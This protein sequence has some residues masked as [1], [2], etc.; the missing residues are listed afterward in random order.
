MGILAQAPNWTVNPSDYQFTSTLTGVL[1][2]NDTLINSGNNQLGAFVNGQV[3]GVATPTQIG[4]TDQYFITL[5]SNVSSGEV[6]TFQAYLALEDSIH[7]VIDT[8]VY[9]SSS[10]YGDPATP[11]ELY[12]NQNNNPRFT[13]VP[14]LGAIATDPFDVI[15]L[16]D[17]TLNP[18]NVA[19]DYQV[20]SSTGSL[21]VSLNQDSLNVM[22]MGDISRDSVLVSIVDSLTPSIR[23]DSTYIVYEVYP[24]NA[25]ISFDSIE[26]ILWG[27]N[28]SFCVDLNNYLV[29]D[30][31]DSIIWTI[32]SSPLDS[33]GDTIVSWSVNAP[34]YQYS[35]NVIAESFVNGISTVGGGFQLAA[36]EGAN[37]IGVTSPTLVN[38]KWLYFMTIY[39]NTTTATID[40]KLWNS[41]DSIVLEERTTELQFDVDGVIGGIDSPLDLS[42]GAYNYQYT[43]GLLCFDLFD[44]IPGLI[45]SILVI[46]TEVNTDELFTDSLE[47]TVS[48][49][50]ENQP[51]LNTIPEQH[52]FKGQSF[53]SF[54]LDDYLI[55]LDGDNVIYEVFNNDSIIANIDGNNV[56]TLTPNSAT[57]IGEEELLFKVT[58]QTS[59]GLFSYESVAFTV[60]PVMILEGIPDQT[61]TTGESFN[62]ITLFDYLTYQYPDSIEW[63]ITCQSLVAIENNG[64]LN[65]L[66]P[67]SNW[68]GADT[69]VVKAMKINDNALFDTD[70]VI[71]SVL[72][73]SNIEE[74]DLS[75]I[76][77]YP[78]PNRG[79]FEVVSLNYDFTFIEVY[80]PTG[81]L[82]L[83]TDFNSRMRIKIK[84]ATG[85]YFIRLIG[86]EK[87]AILKTIIE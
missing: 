85:L 48:Y 31:Q 83:S 42:F 74:S 34:A 58:D 75:L 22:H 1:I 70:T 25:P 71:Y 87:V 54:D 38:G 7:N 13:N 9:T 52:I 23:Y 60:S 30:D 49:F 36:F 76:Q 86:E 77:L 41:T 81:K 28:S 37:L 39:S 44:S 82:V 18:D 12:L 78:N 14:Q 65:I 72:N 51:L 56:V 33:I 8:L 69:V 5:Y 11:F 19:V 59:N 84:Q 21:S 67:N 26:N 17:F 15:S 2:I 20:L 64:E 57:W 55:E 43:N 80:D 45:D 10:V 68:Y 32:T 27:N 73:T 63:Q 47:F 29:N 61:I 62:V 24:E 35:M 66:F 50:D 40:F 79:E 3:R 4:A 46:A 53:I 16:K 6:F